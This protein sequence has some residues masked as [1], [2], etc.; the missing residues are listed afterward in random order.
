M[1]DARSVFVA[2]CLQ[3]KSPERKG[4]A[5]KIQIGV[6]WRQL[7]PLA[8]WLQDFAGAGV[9]HVVGGVASLVTILVTGPR[10][11]RAISKTFKRQPVCSKGGKA[12]EKE[13]KGC[14]SGSSGMIPLMPH[15]GWVILVYLQL[16]RLL[17]PHS[18]PLVALGTFILFF[19][20]LFFNGASVLTYALVNLQ[21]Y[22]WTHV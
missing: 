10:Y 6:L 19:A 7:H 21:P 13:R 17:Q 1:L 5:A 4:C 9:V 15:S 22:A 18:M 2:L 8:S 20:F 12:P 3:C 16:C 11:E 14:G